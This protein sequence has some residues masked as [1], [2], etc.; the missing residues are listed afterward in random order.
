[1]AQTSAEI[2]DTNRKV[3]SSLRTVRKLG[4]SLDDAILQHEAAMEPEDVKQVIE[5]LEGKLEV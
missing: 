4:G 3:L 2:R 5:K 1:M